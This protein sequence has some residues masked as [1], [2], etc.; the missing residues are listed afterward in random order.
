M[1]TGKNTESGIIRLTTAFRLSV[2][3]LFLYCAFKVGHIYYDYFLLQTYARDM[4]L[5]P[6]S[7]NY[8]AER[9]HSKFDKYVVKISA[10]VSSTSIKTYADK[11]KLSIDVEYT[12]Y[13]VL[14]GYDL[15]TF[16][17]KITEVREY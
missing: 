4:L 11:E 5:V 10:P 8:T 13:L 6:K 14:F 2:L 9:L 15:H 1:R 7:Y 16:E 3:G 12:D 17:F